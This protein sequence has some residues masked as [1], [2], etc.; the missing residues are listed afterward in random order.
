MNCTTCGHQ[1]SEQAKF[2]GECGKA[3]AFRCPTC[4]ADIAPGLKFCTDCGYALTMVTP[5]PLPPAIPHVARLALERRQ[6]TVMFCDLV[7]STALSSRLD[8]E[9][10]REVI[11]CYQSA[12]RDVITRQ[13]L[14]GQFDLKDLGVH[15]LKGEQRL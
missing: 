3:L 10:L 9:D 13:L 2:C 5:A 11:R 14:A 12:P 4:S 7:D 1:N 6:L 8:P 15:A